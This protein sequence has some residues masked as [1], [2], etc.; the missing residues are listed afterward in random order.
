MIGKHIR[1]PLRN[2]FRLILHILPATGYG[3]QSRKP[4][5]RD[6]AAHKPTHSTG[7]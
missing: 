6:T 3:K 4:G 5:N 1:S 7:G 2:Q